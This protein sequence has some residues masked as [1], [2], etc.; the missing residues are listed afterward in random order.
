MPGTS[1][2]HK[3]L[4]RAHDGMLMRHL[5]RRA[6]GLAALLAL[7]VLAAG[8]TAS[9]PKPPSSTPAPPLAGTAAAPRETARVGTPAAIPQP[10]APSTAVAPSVAAGIV[11]LQQQGGGS[12]QTPTVDQRTTAFTSPGSWDLHWQYNCSA[13]GRQGN[14]SVDVYTADGSYVSNPSGLVQIGTGT[15][16]MQQY[17]VAGT[18]YLV[19]NSVCAWSVSAT[20]ASRPTATPI[21]SSSGAVATAAAS[22][23]G[24]LAV[25]ALAAASAT[26]AAPA[27]AA[28]TTA[29][30]VSG[31]STPAAGVSSAA[32]PAAAG[33]RAP[34][35]AQPII[36]SALGT[37][38][39][40]PLQQSQ[41]AFATFPTPSPP[42][43]STP[44]PAITVAPAATASPTR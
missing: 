8:C 36:P 4:G 39:S 17:G 27:A 30:G 7:V 6:C 5:P 31:G 29:A 24:S 3:I 35:G 28:S 13:L 1:D 18:F 23:A 12:P 44:P 37:P 19:I 32:A 26:P 20:T 34:F 43:A 9:S 14:L 33:G 11:L 15:Q 2:G 16:G 22:S 10:A 42:A 21:S 41:G 40:S 38:I 25:G